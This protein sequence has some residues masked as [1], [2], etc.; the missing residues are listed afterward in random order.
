MQDIETRTRTS[1][2]VVAATT[3]VAVVTIVTIVTI[4]AVA[5][6]AGCAGEDPAS[7]PYAD[8]L[9]EFNPAAETHF[10]HDELPD[11][12]L[13]PPGG[14]LDVASLG[15]EGSIVVELGEPG[16]V[17]GPGPDFIVFENAFSADF[18][19]PGEVAV[20]E[21]GA[22]WMV[23][24]CDPLTLE[25]C[26]GVTP[27]LAVPGSGLDPTDPAQAGGDAFDLGALPEHPA[28]VRYVRIVDRSRAYWASV[29]DISYCDPGNQGA[30]GFDLDAI[31][32]VH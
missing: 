21:D 23:F 15:C 32:A 6:E 14:V 3:M 4:V 25:G 28:Q 11:I 10:G 19:E 12:V 27:T 16:V 30:G 8:A 7:D 20:S 9:V 31:A 17:D 13:G 26:A 18:P 2:S 1:S 24:A 22:S 5:A 29:G